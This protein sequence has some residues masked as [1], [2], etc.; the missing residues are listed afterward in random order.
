MH[1]LISNFITFI[2]FSIEKAA[3][4]FEKFSVSRSFFP[5]TTNYGNHV[6]LEGTHNEKIAIFQA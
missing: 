3:K 5:V 2:L 4:F 6:K 1:T